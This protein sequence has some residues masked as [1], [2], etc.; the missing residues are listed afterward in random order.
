[1]ATQDER[2]MELEK[3]VAVHLTECAGRYKALELVVIKLSETLQHHVEDTWEYR[4][5][6]AKAINTVKFALVA[7][8]ALVILTNAVGPAEAAKLIAGLLR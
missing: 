1:M 3:A 4:K 8:F 6:T 7:G 2:L 5:T